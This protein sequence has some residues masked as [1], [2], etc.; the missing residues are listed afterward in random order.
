[1][2]IDSTKF[3]Q[4]LPVLMTS[5]LCGAAGTTIA[6]D[7]R[8]GGAADQPGA[9]AGGEVGSGVEQIAK[10]RGPGF[11]VT[12]D[13]NAGFYSEADFDSNV[14]TIESVSYG[15]DLGFLIPIDD[16]ARLVLTLGAEITDYDITPAAGVGGTTAAT[17]GTQFDTITEYGVNAMYFRSIN[18]ETSFFVGGGVGIAAEGGASDAF[19]W[20][21]LGGMMFQV[22]DKLRLGAGIG[23]FSQ[24]ED[25]VQIIP[26]PQIQ[27]TINEYWSL[28]SEGPGIKLEYKWSDDLAMGAM[29][30]FNGQSFR[31]DDDNTLAPDGAVNK[32]AIPVSYYIDYKG[33]SRSQ[34]SLFAEVG[35]VLGGNMEILNS[36]G[37]VIVDEDYDPSVFAA[38]GLKIRF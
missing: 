16:Q 34:I 23:I 1:M 36:Q 9:E 33:A 26:L 25:D 15:A 28:K 19:V 35:M 31:I 24:I 17:V 38:F 30:R 21:V 20:N 6:Q 11:S 22:N 3:S 12:L 2:S 37:T 14:G 7:G 10:S 18:K 29:A 32:R 8:P 5:L 4:F 27:L 13:L